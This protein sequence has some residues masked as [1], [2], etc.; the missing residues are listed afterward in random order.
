MRQLWCLASL[1][2][3][4]ILGSQAQAGSTTATLPVTIQAPLVIV[5]TP[6]TPSIPCNAAP[7]TVVSA[8]SVSGGDGNAMTYTASGGDTSDF[9]ISGSNVVVG[10]N[11][12]AAAHCGQTMNV[13][14]SASQP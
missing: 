1:A 2:L 14:V 3:I 4:A 9:A 7:G 8:A 11:G 10:A 6:A 5:F 12:I 13:T